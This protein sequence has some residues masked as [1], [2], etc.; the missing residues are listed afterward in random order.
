MLSLL[1]S[2]SAR[3]RSALA[4]TAALAVTLVAIQ[5]IGSASAATNHRGGQSGHAPGQARSAAG[6]GQLSG[7]LPRN[8]LTLESAIRVN[9]S[10]ET[11]RLPLYPGD[12]PVP[13]HPGRT[14]HVWYVL[15]DAS[16][17]GLAHDLGVNYAPKLANIA[18]SDPAA[19]Q[20]VTLASPTPAQNRFGPALV[21]FQGAPNFAPTRSAVP[22]PTGFPLKSF[23][24]GAIAG[25]GYSPFIRIAGSNVVYNAPIVATGNGPFDVVHHTNTGDRVLKVHIAPR[26]PQGQYFDNY[27]DMLFVKGFDAGQP[28]VYLSTDA[29]QPLTAVLERSTY[30]PALNHASYNGGDDF[31]GSAR[32][33]LFGFINGQTGADNPQ[34][35][36]F[37]H[38]VLDGHASQDASL[39]NK[40]LI[41]ALRH[42][43]DLLNVFGDFPTLADPRHADAYSPLWDAQLGL[44]TAKAVKQG[45]NRRQIDENQVFN[46]AATR[47]DLLTGVNPATGKPAPYGS[48]GVD[49]N[50]AVIGYTAGAPTANLA[51][52]VP[53]S[54]FPPR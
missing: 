48:V 33:R 47:P 20:K 42:G 13:G 9:L 29:G 11:V 43:G 19:V 53:H 45:L 39:G 49:I 12:A 40:A 22:G 41:N 8:K 28:I 2:I 54:Q 23:H 34:A 18:I 7:L 3:G 50:C 27:V 44:W 26:A 24:P 1:K 10:N 32:E 30:V 5:L 16:D 25:P 37:Q 38:L 52:P 4:V 6:L 15:L 17:A 36:G 51:P 14:E 46:L 31:L 35:Q 21:H